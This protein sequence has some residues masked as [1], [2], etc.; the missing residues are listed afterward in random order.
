MCA[1]DDD[2]K[3]LEEMLAEERAAL[4]LWMRKYNANHPPVQL[5]ELERVFASEDDWNSVRET[6]RELDRKVTLAQAHVDSIRAELTAHQADGMRPN[7]QE[8]ET[9]EALMKR[10][11]QLEHQRREI[12]SQIAA[13]DVRLASHEKSMEQIKL[14]T[15]DLHDIASQER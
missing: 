15:Q 4:D 6:V 9:R 8:E 1:L 11:L 5:N 10:K 13:Y 14:C 3:R 12:M 2:S 7:E